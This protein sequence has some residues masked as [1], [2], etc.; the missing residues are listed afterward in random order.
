MLQKIKKAV[1]FLFGTICTLLLVTITIFAL[2]QVGGRYLFRRTFFWVEDV[3]ALILGGMVA[4]GVP[5]VWLLSDHIAVDMIDAVLPK[6]VRAVWDN[7]IQFIAIGVGAV[8]IR[9]G[10]GGVRQNMGFSISMLRYDESIKFYFVV[11]LGILL[12]F[13][14]CLTLLLRFQEGRQTRKD[15]ASERRDSV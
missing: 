1:C 5:W 13:A 12:I 3:S 7:V 15:K 11:V 9:S 8:L 14:A 6:T 10:L 2:M 4:F